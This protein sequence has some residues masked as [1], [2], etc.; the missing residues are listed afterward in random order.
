M[1]TKMSD[2]ELLKHRDKLGKMLLDF[3]PETEEWQEIMEDIE[4]IDNW[5]KRKK[6]WEG[7]GN[8]GGHKRR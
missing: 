8:S 4:E 6:M 2:E 3:E 7:S 1:F 5:K